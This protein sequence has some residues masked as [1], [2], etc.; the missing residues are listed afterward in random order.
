[1]QHLSTLI[2]DMQ[3]ALRAPPRRAAP[4]RASSLALSRP[5]SP[6]AELPKSTDE[7]AARTRA[8][9]LFGADGSGRLISALCDLHVRAAAAA[10]AAAASARC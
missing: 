4:P 7:A 8:Q 2:A 1:M 10:A 3:S 5:L 9:F 6:R